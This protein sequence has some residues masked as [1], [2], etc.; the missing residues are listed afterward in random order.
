MLQAASTRAPDAVAVSE[1]YVKASPPDSEGDDEERVDP[2]PRVLSKF[3]SVKFRNAL[4]KQ[5]ST[6]SE[7]CKVKSKAKF[8]MRNHAKAPEA[9]KKANKPE[10]NNSGASCEYKPGLFEEERQ[11][12]LLQ[13]KADGLS[14]KEALGAWKD[15]PQRAKFLCN[16]S[17][18]ELKRR[19]FV[20]KGCAANPFVAVAAL[21]G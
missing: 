11:I 5:G 21:G 13:A 3:L 12:F 16:L 7:K 8:R 18:P 17:L 6:T 1:Q 15:S 14:H 10:T 9:P 4:G 19:R 20:P 2:G